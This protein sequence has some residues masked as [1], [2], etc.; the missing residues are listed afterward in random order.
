MESSSLLSML[1]VTQNVWRCAKQTS[2]VLGSPIMMPMELA[3]CWRDA[4]TLVL[5]IVTLAGQDKG[6]VE[7]FV[8][9]NFY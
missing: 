5:G 7:K 4:M 1:P 3:L 9:N 6:N 2:L 8:F